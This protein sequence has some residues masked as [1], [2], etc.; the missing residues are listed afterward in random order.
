MD[1]TC[2]HWYETI[3]QSMENLA[4]VPT[5]CNSISNKIL[6]SISFLGYDEINIK[7]SRLYHRRPCNHISLHTLLHIICNYATYVYTIAY[8]IRVRYSLLFTWFHWLPEFLTQTFLNSGSLHSAQGFLVLRNPK[9]R[10]RQHAIWVSPN[11]LRYLASPHPL[12]V[13]RVLVIFLY[14][15]FDPSSYFHIFLNIV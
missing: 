13:V 8:L 6:F 14:T 3:S 5:V 15:H 1:K 9:R 4:P 12:P 2:N 10:D 7:D 11:I